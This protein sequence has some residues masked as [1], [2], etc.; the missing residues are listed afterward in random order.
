MKE[1]A[2]PEEKLAQ[3]MEQKPQ[4]AGQPPQAKGAISPGVRDVVVKIIL[5]AMKIIYTESKGLL[6]V[7]GRAP[8]PQQGIA[9]ATKIVFDKIAQSAKG[10]PPETIQRIY[11]GVARKLGPIVS[12]LLVELAVEAGVVDEAALSGKQDTPAPEAEEA[13]PAPGIVGS[14]MEA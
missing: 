2:M 6:D 8:D 14:E 11:P 1:A 13:P 12:S 9:M 7:I 5:A 4:P 10:V 3:E